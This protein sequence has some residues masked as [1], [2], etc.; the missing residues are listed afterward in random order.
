MQYLISTFDTACSKGYI[1]RAKLISLLGF[2]NSNNI[3]GAYISACMNNHVNIVEWLHSLNII[4]K[5]MRTDMFAR[6]C[7]NRRNREII[8]LIYNTGV[9]IT[10][11]NNTAFRNACVCGNLEVAKWLHSV[12][13]DAVHTIDNKIFDE[14]ALYNRF[15]V[16][17]WL[18]S[19]GNIDSN[20]IQRN[21]IVLCQG[22]TDNINMELIKWIYSLGV[23]IHANDDMAFNSAC[24]HMNVDLAKWLYSLGGIDIYKVRV[25]DAVLTVDSNMKSVDFLYSIGGKDIFVGR[26]MQKIFRYNIYNKNLDTAKFLYSIGGIDIHDK[27]DVAFRI[28]CYRGHFETIKWLYSLGANIHANDDEGFRILC[29]FDYIEQAKW[30]YSLGGVNIHTDNECAF[31]NACMF[32][33]VETITWLHTL[34]ADV[35]FDNDIAYDCIKC[36]NLISKKNKLKLYKLLGLMDKK[37]DVNKLNKYKEMLWRKFF[38]MG[39]MA[40]G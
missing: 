33:S 4:D 38:L 32:E 40:L 37:N 17:K 10:Y 16:A 35:H 25:T 5:K 7:A 36:N 1:L 20:T 12:G 22:Q 28:A 6:M 29:K 18:Y 23:D 2:L 21:F 14:L 9:D 15:E 8:N 11:D 26:D 34:G 13:G 24:R 3:F 19:F 39:E 31:L 30:I 27:D